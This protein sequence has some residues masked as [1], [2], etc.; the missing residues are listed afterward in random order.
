MKGNGLLRHMAVVAFLMILFV[1]PALAAPPWYD[2]P[3]GQDE[4]GVTGK[5][6][7]H[8]QTTPWSP[9][10][11]AL[12]TDGLVPTMEGPAEAAGFVT[13]VCQSQE[14][15]EYG[16]DV[17]GLDEGWYQ[18]IAQPKIQNVFLP[19]DTIRVVESDGFPESVL[20]NNIHVGPS[21]EAEVEGV[22][23]AAPGFY[24][25]QIIVQK[26]DGDEPIVLTTIQPII[27]EPEDCQPTGNL[28]IDIPNCVGDPVDFQVC[29]D[30]GCPPPIFL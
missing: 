2:G 12:A 25:W 27:S 13:F 4:K 17:K 23:K 19:P 10:H 8:L 7:P 26:L 3:G 15:F 1:S 20:I 29:D 22:V 21:G 14:G 16:V 24:V 11:R 30:T 5:N 6:L 18:I 28:A 9:D